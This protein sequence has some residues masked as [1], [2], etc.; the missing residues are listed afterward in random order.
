[1]E[2]VKKQEI[3]MPFKFDDFFTTQEQRDE[4][5]KEKIEEID[6]SLIDDFKNHPFKVVENAELKSLTDSINTNGVLS[7]VILREKE[8]G[9]YEMISGHRRKFAC[10]KL[11]IYKIPSII[12]NLS[13]DEATIFMVDS[14]LQR[15]KLLP[16]EKAFAY[17]MKYDAIKHQGRTLVPQ[18]QNDMSSGPVDRRWSAEIIGDEHGESEKTVRRYIRLTYLIP[19]LLQLADNCELKENPSIALRPAVEISYLTK[20]EQKVL[21][22]YIEMNLVTPSHAQAIELRNLSQKGLLVEETID[23]VMN[24]AKPNQIP[25]FKI[26]ESKLYKVLPNNIDREKIEDYILKACDYYAKHLKMKDD[27]SR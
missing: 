3:P 1:M 23:N 17:K 9:R 22:D 18:N 20:E 27:R 24:R 16:S 13:D 8:N 19:E 21:Y 4:D 5:K 7:P 10:Q 26:N 2:E 11:G 6:I 15:E 14:N 25:K 12:K